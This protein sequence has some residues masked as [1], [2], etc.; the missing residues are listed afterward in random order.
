[1][2]S[3]VKTELERAVALDARN[4][5]A[6]EALADFYSMA[7]E[8]MGGGTEKARAQA[9]AVARLDAPR[10][11]LAF[12]RLAIHAND[13]T[14]VERELNAAIAGAP[15]TLPA[16]TVLANWYMKSKQWPQA[17]AT[18]DRYI[19]RRPNDLYGLYAVGRIAALSGQQLERGE[20]GIRTF[21]A[22]PP[23]DAPPPVLARAHL[24]LVPELHHPRK[25]DH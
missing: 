16:Y 7:P 20:Q 25:P 4:I 6:L 19:E 12:G 5:E 24:R 23:L 1:L 17:F 8:F 10:G 9:E 21:L 2:A 13:S 3:Q 15:D 22:K 18:I 11:H 14:A